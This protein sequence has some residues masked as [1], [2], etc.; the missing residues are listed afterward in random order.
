MGKYLNGYMRGPRD[1]IDGAAGDVPRTYRPPGWTAWDVAGWGYPEFNYVLNE[2]GVLQSYGRHRQDYL[3]DVLARDGT[4]F[5]T[6]AAASH[7]PFFLELATF[8][9]H[10]PYVPAPQDARSFPGLRAPRPKSFDVLPTHAPSWLAAHPPL[11]GEQIRRIDRVFRRRVQS[12]QA[13]D[14]MIGEIE[15]T[16][17]AEGIANDT[18]LVF[19]SDNG[20]HTGE[21]RLM[22][23]KLTAFDTDI[24][25]PLVVVGPGVPAGRT[26]AAMAENIDLAETF[27]GIGHVR[28]RGDGRSLLPLLHGRAVRRWR[29]GVLVEHRGRNTLPTDPDYQQPASGSPLTYEAMRTRQFLYVEYDDGEREFYNLKTDP[30]ELHNIVWRLP[31]RLLE[32]LHREL[33]AMVQCHGRDCWRA[34]HVPRLL[35]R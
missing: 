11:T 30:Y 17:T 9:P 18:Y 32:R 14:R 10:R 8:A 26:T 1:A 16:L 3:T 6:R 19:S 25:V 27:A 12:V 33:E 7:R 31:S 21:Y 29:T 13:V 34:M 15:Q 23:G 24:H 5:I 22:P 2:N 35:R 28:L 20:L 4:T